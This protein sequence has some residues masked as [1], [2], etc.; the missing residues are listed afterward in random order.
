MQ[1]QGWVTINGVGVPATQCGMDKKT[2]PIIPETIWGSGWKI[3]YS[4]GR[5]TYGGD[6]TFPMFKSYITPLKALVVSARDTGVDVVVDDSLNKFTYGTSKVT[7]MR[8]SG[9]A[10]GVVNCALTFASLSRTAAAHDPG[11]GWT[12]PTT[13]STNTEI[14]FPGFTTAFTAFG[15]NRADV[16]DWEISVNNNPFPLYTL[17]GS[18][19]PADIQLGHLDVTGSFSYYLN[20]ASGF[21]W[22]SGVVSDSPEDTNALVD[23]NTSCGSIALDGNALWTFGQGVITD[24]ARPLDGPNNKPIRKVGFRLLG[25][26]TQAPL[27]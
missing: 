12:T 2:E 25:T 9:D 27:Y 10:K 13:Q 15:I 21:G 1:Y 23:T 22:L 26:A 6:V 3:N 18:Q 11:S 19:D 4:R 5:N 17:N 24:A 16:I 14:P 8:L 7:A 20:S